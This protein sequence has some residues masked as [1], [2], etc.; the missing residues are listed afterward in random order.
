MTLYNV[1]K[2]MTEARRIAAEYRK[3]TGKVLGISS[4]IA[5]FD[6]ARLMNLELSEVP[7]VGY[8][9]IGRGERQGK[10]VQIKGRAIFDE[11]KSGARLGQLKTEQEW[12]LVM[13][14][15]MDENY[16]PVEIR[17]AERAAVMQALSESESSK[18]SKRGAMSVAKFKYVSRLVWTREEGAVDDEI[19]DNQ[20]DA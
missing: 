13:V 18:R 9:A 20:A 16:E 19:W 1:D 2:L 6:A 17:E 14:V 12:D 10:R 11:T 7:N 3:A 15:V 8:D 5:R 4:E